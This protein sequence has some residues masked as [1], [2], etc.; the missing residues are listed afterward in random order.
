MAAG[1]VTTTFS[2]CEDH[3]LWVSLGTESWNEEQGATY[4]DNNK[5]VGGGG[6][7]PGYGGPNGLSPE[8]IAAVVLYE[9]VTF[10]NLDAAEVEADCNSV[11]D[12]AAAN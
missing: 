11:L 3:I 8:Q 5:P 6:T 7:M 9:R 4:G 1:A 12:A 2:S 10:G